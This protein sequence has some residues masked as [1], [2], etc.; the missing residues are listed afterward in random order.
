M[1][2][3]AKSRLIRRQQDLM[4]F[5]KE[6][7][8]CQTL[9][10][11]RE[12][13][14]NIFDNIESD[15]DR[16]GIQTLGELGA[17]IFAINDCRNEI[18][19]TIGAFE[20]ARKESFSKLHDT[21]VD[22]ETIRLNRSYRDPLPEYQK[23][24]AR[25]EPLVATLFVGMRIMICNG[26]KHIAGPAFDLSHAIAI[27]ATLGRNSIHPLA[28]AMVN[29]GK[30]H[31]ILE[32]ESFKENPEFKLEGVIDN[33]HVIMGM[34]EFILSKKE[35]VI[36]PSQG[37]S[38]YL[39]VGD[40]L[41]AFSLIDFNAQL[42]L[43][44]TLRKEIEFDGTLRMVCGSSDI[45]LTGVQD[46]DIGGRLVRLHM[47]EMPL[48]DADRKKLS[49]VIQLSMEISGHCLANKLEIRCA[50]ER[51]EN[52]FKAYKFEQVQLYNTIHA[53]IWRRDFGQHPPEQQIFKDPKVAAIFKDYS[54]TFKQS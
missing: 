45:A 2:E 11:A 34:R 21:D 27:A 36:P 20:E 43:G 47:K 16:R 51:E 15:R 8:A 6:Y 52:I 33:T 23:C 39:L 24:I 50:Y 48:D 14:N 4:T 38:A 12:R 19:K 40:S 32:S 42:Q 46:G 5:Y 49:L 9:Q 7:Q 41:F 10:T 44:Y 1:T 30:N 53:R 35:I 17:K 22:E 29:F 37:V 28:K 31:P 26:V 13:C 54:L 25:I 18:T 3:V